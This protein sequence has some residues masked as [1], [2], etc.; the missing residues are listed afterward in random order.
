MCIQDRR[1]RCNEGEW[2]IK[3]YDFELIHCRAGSGRN[4]SRQRQLI[5]SGSNDLL[6]STSGRRYSKIRAKHRFCFI[7]WRRT[8]QSSNLGR[9]GRHHRHPT[10]SSC[11][12]DQSASWRDT[13]HS[14]TTVDDRPPTWLV[15]RRSLQYFRFVA[16]SNFERRRSKQQ[17]GYYLADVWAVRKDHTY[18]PC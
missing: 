11:R 17:L 6:E 10:L 2:Y 4:P 14:S 16:R 5:I 15:G 13:L 12:P 18:T 9:S 3:F 7:R 1:S 8:A